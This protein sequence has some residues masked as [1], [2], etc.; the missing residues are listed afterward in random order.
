MHYLV[1]TEHFVFERVQT[2]W[3]GKCQGARGRKK[4]KI[5]GNMPGS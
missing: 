4:K 2:S 5:V 3:E 1:K